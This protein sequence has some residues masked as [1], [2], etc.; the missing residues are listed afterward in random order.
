MAAK[1][2]TPFVSGK[3]GKMSG[4]GSSTKVSK[5]APAKMKSK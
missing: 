1:L 5:K 2:D 4:G 3:L